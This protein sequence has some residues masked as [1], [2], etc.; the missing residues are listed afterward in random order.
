MR[1]ATKILAYSLGLLT[2]P[3]MRSAWTIAPIPR[4]RTTET[5]MK[6]HAPPCKERMAPSKIT[7]Q[8]PRLNF[9]AVSGEPAGALAFGAS[10]ATFGASA[11]SATTAGGVS[12][13]SFVAFALSS[14]PPI[15]NPRYRLVSRL[16]LSIKPLFESEQGNLRGG[17]QRPGAASRHASSP[18][19]S[20]LR[21]R[22]PATA[23]ARAIIEM[24]GTTSKPGR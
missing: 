1:T 10:A 21:K 4:I 9:M 23:P 16:R 15:V 20:G 22:R 3:R 5:T 13:L 18:S 8:P 19:S 2:L 12:S 7:T 17:A 24:A 6:P 14:N 11:T